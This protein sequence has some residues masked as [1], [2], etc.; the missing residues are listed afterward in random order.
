MTF[1]AVSTRAIHT[2]RSAC[3]GSNSAGSITIASTVKMSSTTSHPTATCP[4]VECSELLSD[5]TRT[6]TTVLATA[7][8]TP[9]TM[10]PALLQPIE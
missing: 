3:S 8:A 1:S 7:N 2:G 6:T 9:K 10:P 5:K 4:A